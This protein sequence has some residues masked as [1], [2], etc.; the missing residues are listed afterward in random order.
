MREIKFRAWI[1]SYKMIVE[2]QRINF[3]TR[4][5][6]VKIGEGDLYEFDFEEI[7]LIQYTGLKDKNS[8]KIYEGDILRVTDLDD[9][10][11]ALNSDT[12]IG[13]VEWLDKWGFWNI[14][15]IGNGLG[16]LNCGYVEII[17]NIHENPELLEELD[18]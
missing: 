4:T 5:I 11:N 14:S 18:E 16:I 13:V 1:K 3:D 17:G 12:G 9:E 2:V 8:K 7:K 10:V 15:N 6:E